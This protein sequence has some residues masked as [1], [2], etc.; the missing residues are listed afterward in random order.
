MRI[1]N[2][3]VA[4]VVTCVIAFVFFGVAV[5]SAAN[6]SVQALRQQLKIQET[7]LEEQIEELRQHRVNIEQAWVRV[8]RESADHLRAQE[9]DENI[10]SLRLRDTD[11]RLAESELLMLVFEAQ[12]LRRAVITTRSL[13]EQTIA[14]IGNLESAAGP[15]SDPITGTWHVFLEPG[16]QEGQ[17]YL[18]L[19]GTLVQ[20][21]YRLNGEWA[22]SLRGT[23]VARK[24]RLERIDEQIG[25]AAI[26]YGQL[27]IDDGE[28]RLQGRWEATQLASGLPSAGS[29]VAVRRV[30]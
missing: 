10:E 25:F 4:R 28:S 24:I 17:F 6:A 16:G 18:E 13:I 9:Q 8:G 19:Q 14:G 1:T 2:D 30:D 3:P 15:E 27:S 12:R 22:G 23:L 26:L 11:L 5:C 20:G 29:W 21:T 7:I